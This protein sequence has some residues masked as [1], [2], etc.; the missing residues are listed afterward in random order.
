[1][2]NKIE[3]LSDAAV[4]FSNSFYVNL[5]AKCF[6]VCGN[7]RAVAA[8]LTRHVHTYNLKCNGYL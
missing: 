4:I 2:N 5:N 8:T 6:F 3:E 7:L 1:M